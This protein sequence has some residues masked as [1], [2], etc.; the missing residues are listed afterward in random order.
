MT[1]NEIFHYVVLRMRL[2]SWGQIHSTVKNKAV[3]ISR[4]LAG[5]LHV[6][7]AITLGLPPQFQ[8]LSDILLLECMTSQNSQIRE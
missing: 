3:C 5:K 1:A 6:F 2:M 7:F 8:Y 4:N